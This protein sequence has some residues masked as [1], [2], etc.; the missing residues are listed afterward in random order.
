[1]KSILDVNLGWQLDGSGVGLPR[2][3]AR[4]LAQS[5]N[6]EESD[7]PGVVSGGIFLTLVLVVAAIIWAAVT[8][9]AEVATAQG[10]VV[11]AGLNH[12]VQHLE[13]GIIETIDVRDGDAVQAGQL[14]LRV[15]NR[16]PK[17]ERSQILA[18]RA[19]LLLESERIL[20][21]IE[22]REP[23]FGELGEHWPTLAARQLATLTAQ[24]ARLNS[25][26][27]LAQARV[28]QR[29]AELKRQLRQIESG[30]A[31]LA[32]LQEQLAIRESLAARGAFSTDDLLSL[33]ARL[34][35]RQGQLAAEEDSVAVAQDA[36]EESR[37]AVAEVRS[38]SIEQS[39]LEIGRIA[40]ELAEV[41]ATLLRLEDAVQRSEIRAPVAG[42][43]QGLAVNTIGAVIEPGA[44]LMELVP[45]DRQLIV[46]ARISPN[47][48]GHIK[49]GQ[50]VDIKVSSYDP[51]RYGSV[52]GQLERI[53]ASTF[54][55]EQGNPYY[56]A[57]VKL[58]KM[59]VGKDAVSHPIIP[60][61]TVRADVLTG[62]KSIL[63]YLMKP[64]YRGFQRAFTER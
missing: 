50:P 63:D 19:T 35:D 13:G 46:E 47:D 32:V 7:V 4:Y 51:A 27:E 52:P 55:D 37:R 6:L 17:S 56:R 64:I 16:V 31:E 14:L 41:E 60:G 26:L 23:E 20:A 15:A 48:I 21:L 44:I 58:S 38:R 9:V 62:E 45:A 43:V 1:M 11:P 53:S 28:R 22:S 39:E 24:K 2:A 54:L 36:L 40:G 10:K 34:L 8:V 25:Q 33:Q 61:M 57:E 3:R 59:H 29:E 42:V 30:R 18:R 12:R 49:I 5:I